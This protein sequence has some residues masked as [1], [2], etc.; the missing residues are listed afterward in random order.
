MSSDVCDLSK[1]F[2]IKA[3]LFFFLS[4]R[5]S[6]SALWP[7]RK[8]FSQQGWAKAYKVAIPINQNKANGK[9]AQGSQG[10]QSANTGFWIA[11]TYHA[12]P[13]S[14]ASFAQRTDLICHMRSSV[15]LFRIF[16]LRSECGKSRLQATA[17]S[18]SFTSIHGFTC[19]KSMELLLWAAGSLTRKTENILEDGLSNF[20][21]VKN[22]NRLLAFSCAPGS[23]NLNA[24]L[25]LDVCLWL[26]PPG[27]LWRAA[28]AFSQSRKGVDSTLQ[29]HTKAPAALLH[30]LTG[31]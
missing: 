28:R 27:I 23:A 4:S 8:G 2:K 1:D 16:H 11:A 6:T 13:F 3:L 20:S 22:Q 7:S 15:V 21:S 9:Q 30:L 19:S 12:I 31:C 18:G 25:C 5:L 24:Q 10:S 29:R 14:A 26:F 17:A